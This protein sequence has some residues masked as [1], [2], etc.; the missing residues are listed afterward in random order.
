[1]AEQV[2]TWQRVTHFDI[3]GQENFSAKVNQLSTVA[4][5]YYKVSSFSFLLKCEVF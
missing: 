2:G 1:M 4:Y 5:C 3:P